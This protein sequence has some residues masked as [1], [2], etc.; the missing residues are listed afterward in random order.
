MLKILK[1]ALI[2][3][4]VGV[5]LSGTISGS[6]DDAP[7]SFTLGPREDVLALGQ[8]GLHC[9]PDTHLGVLKIN[10]TYHAW[11]PAIREYIGKGATFHMTGN[12]IDNLKVK[13]DAF[14]LAEPLLKPGGWNAMIDFS[15]I[16]G[17]NNWYYQE[18]NGF[19]YRD[20]TF[21]ASNNRW[22]GSREFCLI[23]PGWLHPDRGCEPV[24]KWVSPVAT[25]VTITGNVP[26]LGAGGGDGVIV[27][28]FKNNEELW[29]RTVDNG[30]RREHYFYLE[31]PVQVGD[32]IY[33]RINM[34]NNPDYDTTY[35]N[36]TITVPGTFDNGYAGFGAVYLDKISGEILAFYHAEDHEGLE[37]LLCSVGAPAWYGS[38][39]L[40]ISR[41][42]GFTFDKL[43]QVI[44]SN[45]PKNTANPSPD[46]AHGVAGP[47][48]IADP[49]GQYLYMYFAELPRYP[50][51]L[52]GI[53]LAR[54]KLEDRGRPGTWF[55]YYNGDFTEPGLGGRATHVVTGASTPGGWAGFPSVSFNTYLN[56][57]LMVHVGQYGFYLR[58]SKN[59][60][61]WS[62]PI[63]LL[64]ATTNVPT[65][66]LSSFPTI[67][68]EDDTHTAQ[69]NWLYYG[70]TPLPLTQE[71]THMVRARLTLSR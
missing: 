48:V 44:T 42:N 35:F 10:G 56:A 39:G 57:Y 27:K 36:P 47:A 70:F 45:E 9:F 17:R 34:R 15:S 54:S 68:G 22:K 23:G 11:F 33:F 31:V 66:S 58:T 24:R 18:W 30:D 29:S 5:S 61:Y 16:Q 52:D 69:T 6:S 63:E 46:G 59:G 64:R 60:I 3:I 71:C 41:D 55:K 1:L 20:M 53:A 13:L 38:V 67:I 65:S 2:V 4:A 32:A 21:D 51:R 50:P 12:S 49:T 43:G 25:R 37:G 8:F 40:A 62:D 7:F 19:A 28:I 26:D 14:G